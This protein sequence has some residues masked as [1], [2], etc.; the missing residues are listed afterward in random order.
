MCPLFPSWNGIVPNIN[1]A[2]TSLDLRRNEI[3]AGGA[4]AIAGSLLQSA[5]KRLV[6]NMELDIEQLKTHISIHLE[7]KGLRAE[8]AIIV[9]KCI[10]FNRA[11]KSANL[12]NNKIGDEG[13]AALSKALKTNS[14]LETLELRSKLTSLYLDGN[15]IGAGGAKAIAAA[16]PQS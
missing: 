11:L 1:R 13:T 12:S 10:E 2:L 8:E 4:E 9:A 6:I 3:G 5:L 15:K 16:L 7:R 14:T